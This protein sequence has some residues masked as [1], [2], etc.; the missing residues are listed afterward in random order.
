MPSAAAF[1]SLFLFF[2]AF[3]AQRDEIVYLHLSDV[4][5]S[6]VANGHLA[7][8]CLLF[9]YDEHVRNS[10]ELRVADFLADL[11]AADVFVGS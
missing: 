8:G 4:A 11:F 6:A 5:L 2:Y 9:A 1:Y 10:F 7:R 3:F